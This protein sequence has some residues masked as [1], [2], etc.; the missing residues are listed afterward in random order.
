MKKERIE[1]KQ[2]D[3]LSPNICDILG[4]FNA[5]ALNSKIKNTFIKYG[6]SYLN[7]KVWFKP[8]WSS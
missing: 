1:K 5:W 6:Y 7:Q 8:Q 3:V 2:Y 4:D